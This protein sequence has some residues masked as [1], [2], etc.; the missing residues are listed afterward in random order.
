MVGLAIALPILMFALQI[1]RLNTKLT[2]WTLNSLL[3]EKEIRFKISKISGSFPFHMTLHKINIEDRFG[4]CLKIDKLM[5]SCK[6]IDILFGNIH[7]DKILASAITIQRIPSKLLEMNDDPIYFPHLT[8][9]TCQIQKLCLPSLYP[10]SIGLQAKI[11]STRD[12]DHKIKVRFLDQEN[13][14]SFIVYNQKGIDYHFNLTLSKDLSYFRGLAPET[15]EAIRHGSLNLKASLEGKTDFILISGYFQGEVKDLE[16]ELP[17][18]KYIV[19]KEAQ[20]DFKFTRH[21]NQ[22]TIKDGFVKTQAGAR[23]HLNYQKTFDEE[24]LGAGRGELIIPHCEH[25]I[26]TYIPAHG[27]AHMTFVYESKGKKDS[28]SA[29]FKDLPWGNPIVKD[30]QKI[31]HLSLSVSRS[32]EHM[33]LSGDLHHPNLN[34]QLSA[35]GHYDAPTKGMPHYVLEF[36]TLK[37]SGF[38][39]STTGKLG[40][41]SNTKSEFS[42]CQNS[43]LEQF[44]ILATITDL[45]PLGKFL[46]RDMNGSGTLM[47]DYKNKNLLCDV[48]LLGV[49]DPMLPQD[50]EFQKIH[51]QGALKNWDG[52]LSCHVDTSA[53]TFTSVM[54][55]QIPM[56]RGEQDVIHLNLKEF[57][58]VYNDK[59]HVALEKSQPLLISNR[60]C[61]IPQTIF[62]VGDGQLSLKNIKWNWA[63][64][65][66]KETSL[67][68]LLTGEVVLNNFSAS[69]LDDFLETTKLQGKIKGSLVFKSSSQQKENKGQKAI[70]YDLE[71]FLEKFG[72]NDRNRKHMKVID[73]SFHA[74]HKKGQLV[75]KGSIVGM[76]DMDSKLKLIWTG[77]AY[78]GA[79]FPVTSNPIQSSLTG[80]FDMSFLNGFFN[81][82]DRYKGDLTIDLK[83][84]GPWGKT[85]SQGYFNLEKGYFENAAFGMILKDIEIRT[86]LSSNKLSIKKMTARDL[87][88]GKII[89]RGNI[90]LEDFDKPNV[91]INLQIDNIL[92]AN[93]DET[94][95]ST[96]G[97]LQLITAKG[98]AKNQ[99]F[100]SLLE[101]KGKLTLNSALIVL[102]NITAEPKNIRV[103][104]DMKD[105]ER[106]ETKLKEP[107]GPNVNIDI[108]IPHKLYIQGYGLH[109]EW[110]GKLKVTGASTSPD[111]NGNISSMN[112]HLDV[113]NKRLTLDK[114]SISFTKIRDKKGDHLVPVLNIKAKKVVDEYVAY[115][116]ITGPTTDPKITFTA[117]PALSTEE[118]IALILFNKPLKNAS[119]AQSLQLATALAAFKT[120]SLTGGAFD[121]LSQI[122]GVDDIGFQNSNGEGAD[123]L[124]PSALRIGKQLNDR[125]YVGVE[126]GIQDENETKALMKID[127]TKNTKIDLETGTED[128][129]VGYNWEMRY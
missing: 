82:E 50:L 57:N 46:D 86:S 121:S 45:K 91:N 62:R 127:L 40:L 4:A 36:L 52:S 101:M 30:P 10:G 19:G 11:T 71:L 103:Y 65:D 123:A 74:T 118:V 43:P 100:D 48:I 75:W 67:E 1:P 47:A 23:L 112:G 58:Y 97:Q 28:L 8:I 109:S 33:I 16:S 20:A 102:N 85:S 78:T 114:S 129:A 108:D 37:G 116:Q 80:T 94:M 68:Q 38:D 21:R 26:P 106:K 96:S 105:L 117:D 42:L 92:L 79:F 24:S 29:T 15:I 14:E 119:A 73:G 12:D 5:L 69:S 104:R 89:G 55:M 88:K 60:V 126:Q 6:G 95:V 64:L 31:E 84:Q 9:D 39:L 59:K 63:E 35:L 99:S 2:E 113:T 110:L 18:V 27:S 66:E 72:V 7:F 90:D 115:V 56:E 107:T 41:S 32:P 120:G 128:S 111:I 81:W 77:S 87:G 17:F 93:T 49:N 83:T 54:A 22:V 61:S 25:L 44:K 53:G 124:T 70:A 76:R 125:I 98:K 51:I 34:V 122:L 3:E 13:H